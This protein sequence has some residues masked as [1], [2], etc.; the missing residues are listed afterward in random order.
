M[1]TQEHKNRSALETPR[2]GDYWHEMFC[3]YFLIVN[4]DKDEYTVLSCLG[5]PNSYSRKHELNAKV[6][7]KDGWHFD[8][9]KSMKVDRA[10]ISKALTYSTN[11]QFVADVV[12][13]DRTQRVVAEWRDWTQKQIRKQIDQLESDWEAFT[14]W[15]TLKEETA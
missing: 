10:W 3:P 8:Y 2:P 15:K 13:S 7:D 9:S 4:V 14:G 6:D 5:G 1:E 11:N 12:N